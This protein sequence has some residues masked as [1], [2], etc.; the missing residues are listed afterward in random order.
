MKARHFLGNFNLVKKILIA[1]KKYIIYFWFL[2]LKFSLMHRLPIKIL[3]Q[4]QYLF[5]KCIMIVLLL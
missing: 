1:K 4:T 3:S 2:L 5:L